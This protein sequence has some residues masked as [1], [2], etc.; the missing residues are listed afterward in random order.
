MS[1]TAITAMTRMMESLPESIQ[2]QVID[3][4]RDYFVKN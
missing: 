2:L 3:Y 1:S 4:L